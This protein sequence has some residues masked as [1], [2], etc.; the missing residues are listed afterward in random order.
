MSCLRWGRRCCAPSLEL[1]GLCTLP[2]VGAGD[3][4]ASCVVVDLIHLEI[5][6]ADDRQHDAGLQR[7]AICGKE[8]IQRA[9]E[10]VVVDLA[11]ETRLALNNPTHS[12][13]A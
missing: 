9:C 11:L 13:I 10:F 2:I 3:H 8:P 7:G 4:D 1:D 5:K 6:S 12:S